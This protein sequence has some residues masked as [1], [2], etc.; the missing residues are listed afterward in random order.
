MKLVTLH[1]THTP[2]AHIRRYIPVFTLD[3][4]GR[5]II[6]RVCRWLVCLS[7]PR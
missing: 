2:Y 1:L 7:I 4:K 6:V 5:G 3:R